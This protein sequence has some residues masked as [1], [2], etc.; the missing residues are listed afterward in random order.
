M[1]GVSQSMKAM[2]ATTECHK[3]RLYAQEQTHSRWS[4]EQTMY[5]LRTLAS[6][7]LLLFVAH[8]ISVSCARGKERAREQGVT[9][10]P[11]RSANHRGKF[12]GGDVHCTWTS[13]TVQETVRL[14]VKC[15]DPEARVKGGV[16]E[17]QC[18]YG[19]KPA[20]CA[21]FRSDPKGFWKQ[22]SRAMK[23]LQGKLCQDER[24]LVKAGM[25]KRAPRGA[26]FKL[27]PRNS[28]AA[29]QSGSDWETPP[30]SL[31]EVRPTATAAP[32]RTTACAKR[33]NHRKAAE[34]YCNS[35]W[36]SLC[37][38]FMNLLQSDDC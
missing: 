9:A 13:R 37:N 30:P 1:V 36:A 4:A 38:F 2:C 12:S 27:D 7:L 17:L 29:S 6:W 8:R 15:E 5:L 18:E 31:R 26:H 14:S 25:C 35:S 10:A 19:A 32:D 3:E 34:E 33:A 23:K 16:T 21:G 28:V 20:L 11:R 22:V 24:A